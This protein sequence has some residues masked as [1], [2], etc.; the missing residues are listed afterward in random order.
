MAR[1]TKTNGIV[2]VL[3]L[4]GFFLPVAAF[5]VEIGRAPTVT[6]DQARDML[7]PAAPG[8]VLV[9]VRSAEEFNAGHVEAAWNWPYDSVQ[10][11]TSTGDVPQPLRGRKLLLIC[12]SGWRSAQATLHLRRLG[13]GSV[14]N[15]N[16]GMQEWIGGKTPTCSLAACTL[17]SSTRSTPA[18][19]CRQSPW[20]EQ[21]AV[22]AA[23]FGVKPV[24]M[25]LSLVL[26]ALLWRREA[27]DLAALR[28]G[29]IWFFIGEAFCSINYF[30]FSDQSYL[31]EYI[32]SFGM[33]LCFAF[34]TFAVLEGMDL[35]IIK[36]TGDRPCAALSLCRACVKHAD[37]PCGLRRTFLAVIPAMAILAFMPLTAQPRLDSYNTAI[38]GTPYNYSHPFVHQVYES[39]ACPLA[40]L[41]LLT[42]SLV[43]LLA[44]GQR[45]IP[46]SKVLFAAGMG[47]LGFGLLR[48]LLLGAYHDNQ[49]WFVFWEEITELLLVVGAAWI[50][51]IFRHSLYAEKGT[52]A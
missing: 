12:A 23:S 45:G 39:R 5:W 2:V 15:V 26:V 21:F 8:V 33:V 49:A 14:Y 34:V 17:T 24:Y 51:W 46:L 10:A 19:L 25:A 42:A 20:H 43:V 32:H 29:M 41:A 52:S 35:R 37:V 6:A 48:M 1:L 3:A 18:V 27:R 16:G 30:V 47:P 50:L 38:F 40:G 4:V 13:V 22:V 11:A 31:S 7:S 36:L 44:R 28:R 9:D